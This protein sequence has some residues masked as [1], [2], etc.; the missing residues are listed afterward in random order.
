MKATFNFQRP[1][2]RA[3]FERMRSAV[4]GMLNNSASG[5]IIRVFEQLAADLD[6]GVRKVKPELLGS[7][8][9]WNPEDRDLSE[10]IHTQHC[11]LADLARRAADL[12]E[13]REGFDSANTL[14]MTGLAFF[15][16]GEAAKWIVGRRER[17]AYG[18]MHWL[19]SMATH[20]GCNHY[21]CEVRLDGR[22]R[23]ATVE[24]L[25]LRTLILDRFAGGNLSRAQCE[26]LD[27]WLW[28]WMPD[29]KATSAWPGEAAFRADLDGKG[30]LRSGRRIDGGPALYLATAPLEAKRRSVVKEFH[31]GRIVPSLGVAADFRVEEHVA[32]LEHLRV[33]FESSNDQDP[34]REVRRPVAGNLVEVCVG[35]AEILQDGQAVRRSLRLVD[36]SDAGFGFEATEAEAAHIAV[37]DVMTL[38]MSRN[39][40]SVLGRVT[41]RVPGSIHGN[42][43]I[44]VRAMSDHPK[45]IVLSRPNPQGRSDD[46]ETVLYVAGPDACGSQDSFLVPEKMLHQAGSYEARIDEN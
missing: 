2:A 22:P 42:V 37:D 33:A 41:R 29:I 40:A 44:G 24:S 30:G 16:W 6:A 21:P 5:E 7:P 32:V 27:A 28:E 26:V 18:W 38:R 23:A 10:W 25:F 9:S 1:N 12:F 20:A 14:R 45:V 8:L 3:D 31:G 19:M 15:H 39:G 46:E 35:L 11:E 13:R 34:V 4:R 36:V 43:T 17:P